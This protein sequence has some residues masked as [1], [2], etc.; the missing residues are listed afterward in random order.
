MSRRGDGEGVVHEKWD[1]E[2]EEGKVRE[3]RK[4]RGKGLRMGKGA[5]YAKPPSHVPEISHGS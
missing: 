1:R 5:L 4:K 2:N 3:E